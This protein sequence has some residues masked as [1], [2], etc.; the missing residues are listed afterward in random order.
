MPEHT[1][2]DAP[3]LAYSTTPALAE[4]R[5]HVLV[6]CISVRYASDNKVVSRDKL[7]KL[8]L[9]PNLGSSSPN[10]IACDSFGHLRIS[11]G[12][13]SMPS[14]ELRLVVSFGADQPEE[15]VFLP[16]GSGCRVTYFT[17]TH[18]NIVICLVHDCISTMTDAE[19]FIEEQDFL[20][21]CLEIQD[22]IF[23]SGSSNGSPRD[24]RKPHGSAPIET[25][26]H[27]AVD[28]ELNSINCLLQKYAQTRKA[29]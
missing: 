28:F 14:E 29:S 2:P 17:L 12:Q 22:E 4:P 11:I 25:L 5:S 21:N 7:S 16:V 9:P 8:K 19:L 1:R 13:S 10:S 3:F 20:Y 24:S 18:M 26:P 6:S 23:L 27:E 15:H